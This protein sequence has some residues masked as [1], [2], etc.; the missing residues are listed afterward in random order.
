VD[1]SEITEDGLLNVKSQEI[2][3]ATDQID[4]DSRGPVLV[5]LTADS[6]YELSS[7]PQIIAGG[8]GHLCTIQ[9]NDA[10]DQVTIV[11]T[12]GVGNYGDVSKVLS[13]VGQSVTYYYNGSLWQELAPILPGC[14]YSFPGGVPTLDCGQTTTITRIVD[15]EF[16][17]V[18]WCNDGTAA[19]AAIAEHGQI[20]Y[21]D[22]SSS[23]A[24]DI[25]CSWHVPEDFD[26]TVVTDMVKVKAVYAITSAT[27]PAANEGASWGFAGCSSGVGDTVDCTEGT[28]VNSET[29]DLDVH[30]QW[31]V[32]EDAYVEVTVTNL[33]AGE[34]VRFSVQRDVADTQDDYGQDVGLI[35]F[36][37]KFYRSP[38]SITY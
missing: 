16:L 23:S 1:R 11:D 3:A 27:T 38:G 15:T 8:A 17:P 4:C 26:E 31:D 35:G 22:F 5:L 30:V 12:N 6:T 19:P 20:D 36:I 32:V 14:T 34:W 7:N 2:T 29:A 33:T 10:T 9:W 21:R 13:V 18:G 28:E 37:V 25:L 24:E